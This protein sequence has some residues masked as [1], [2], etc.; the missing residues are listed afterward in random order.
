VKANGVK[1]LDINISGNIPSY[2]GKK[3]LIGY[4][5]LEIVMTSISDI[6]FDIYNE[7]D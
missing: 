2:Y 5:M 1:N 3:N 6:D 4:F 7:L